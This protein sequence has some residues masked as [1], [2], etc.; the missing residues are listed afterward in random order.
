MVIHKPLESRGGR[1][2]FTLLQAHSH[3]LITGKNAPDL[4]FKIRTTHS[5]CGLQASFLVSHAL[6]RNAYK[7]YIHKF[8]KV[9]VYILRPDSAH[10]STVGL[11]GQ[12]EEW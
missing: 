4:T 10:L 6:A 3:R 2:S 8:V 5:K 1:R 12:A 11:P 7:Y 9:C